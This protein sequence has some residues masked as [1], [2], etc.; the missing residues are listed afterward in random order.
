M[1]R[2]QARSVGPEMEVGSDESRA[3]GALRQAASPLFFFSSPRGNFRDKK[4]R[5]IKPPSCPR[6]PCPSMTSLMYS[7]LIFAIK[8]P[9]PGYIGKKTNT[10]LQVVPATQRPL[11]ARR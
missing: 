5:S 9:H 4:S 6:V 10:L 2:G 7:I 8:L 11:P 1:T 3:F